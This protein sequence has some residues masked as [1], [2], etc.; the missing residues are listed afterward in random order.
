MQ[1]VV[2]TSLTFWGIKNLMGIAVFQDGIHPNLFLLSVWNWQ[3]S[4]LG[5]FSPLYNIRVLLFLK[6]DNV[7]YKIVEDLPLHHSYWLLLYCNKMD[8]FDLLSVDFALKLDC[9]AILA[10]SSPSMG[11]LLLGEDEDVKTVEQYLKQFCL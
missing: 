11:N 10:G 6:I 3:S 5:I 9:F 7:N 2:S 4:S 1:L 8:Y